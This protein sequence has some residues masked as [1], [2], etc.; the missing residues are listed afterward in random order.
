MK[1]LL[2]NP[3][4]GM[5]QEQLDARCTILSQ[6]VGPDVELAM[7]CL[8]KSNIELDS[9]LDAALAAP[10]IVQQAKEAERDGF[11]AVVLYC[12]SDPAIDACREALSIPVVGGAQTSLLLLP[13]LARQGG[14][15][16]ADAARIPEKKVFLAGLGLDTSR[17]AGIGGIDFRGVD[18]WQNREAALY[19]LTEAGQE[20]IARTGA[21][22]IILGCLSFLGMA[23]DLSAHLDVPVIDP[24]IAAVSMAESLV[25]QQLTT[26][27]KAYPSPM[28]KDRTWQGGTL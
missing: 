26:S 8:T 6:Y 23:T 17:I 18:V 19:E 11:D 2:I 7:Q 24:A 3:D 10:E 14:V 4:S 28:V 12:F 27:K 22:A 20:L 9:A 15:L 13:Q 5:T 16:L 25:R 1:I 21:Q